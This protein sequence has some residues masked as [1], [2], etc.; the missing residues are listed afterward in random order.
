MAAAES[1]SPQKQPRSAAAAS[2]QLGNFQQGHGLPSGAPG[3]P[4]LSQAACTCALKCM[5]AVSF[6][7]LSSR[8]LGS[9]SLILHICLPSTLCPVQVAVLP[10]AVRT[11]GTA[12]HMLG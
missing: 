10:V 3:K 6:L 11:C 7:A 9:S 1:G 4:A 8:V 12:G 5:S 2:A